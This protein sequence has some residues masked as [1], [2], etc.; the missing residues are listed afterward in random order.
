MNAP[1]LPSGIPVVPKKPPLFTKPSYDAPPLAPNV[2]PVMP[3][4]LP[5]PGVYCVPAPP[6]VSKPALTIVYAEVAALK[7]STPHT[8]AKRSRRVK[9]D[10]RQRFIVVGL[11]KCE[12]CG[13]NGWRPPTSLRRNPQYIQ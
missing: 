12:E 13:R 4:R 6:G 11:E 3:V 7:L 9:G 5:K 1:E 8:T 2:Q 10:F